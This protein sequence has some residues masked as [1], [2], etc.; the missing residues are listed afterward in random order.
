MYALAERLGT[1]FVAA[2]RA[3]P[4]D[5]YVGWCDYFELKAKWQALERKTEL[6][7]GSH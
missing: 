6:N 5:D 7:R 3:M 2:I 1:P 4:Y